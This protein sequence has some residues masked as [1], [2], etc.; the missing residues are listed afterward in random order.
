[1][2]HAGIPRM[3]GVFTDLPDLNI[4]LECV[5]GPSFHD[6]CHADKTKPLPELEVWAVECMN[7]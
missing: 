4:I 6:I 3:C 7:A 5:E 1:M 2:N